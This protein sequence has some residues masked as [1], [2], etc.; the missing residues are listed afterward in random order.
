MTVALD[1]IRT[2]LDQST[3]EEALSREE[4]LLLAKELADRH[5]LSFLV[6]GDAAIE[7][8]FNKAIAERTEAER[9]ALS[10]MRA[11]FLREIS[12]IINQGDAARRINTAIFDELD[13]TVTDLLHVQTSD[14]WRPG[15]V[16][17]AADGTN[18]FADTWW[19]TFAESC[20]WATSQLGRTVTKI[21][22]AEEGVFDF[23]GV[24]GSPAAEDL[25]NLWKN[26]P[27]VSFQVQVLDDDLPIAERV[28][29]TFT[30]DDFAQ[31][32]PQFSRD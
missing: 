32:V 24:I 28:V 16:L 13:D 15:V 25:M 2:I 7:D 20:A 1:A 19:M 14:A 11:S 22:S 31:K 17:F 12:D 18:I 30:P 29:K 10:S 9:T 3:P 6:V 5:G 27:V 26:K 4:T 23:L 21:A 8:S